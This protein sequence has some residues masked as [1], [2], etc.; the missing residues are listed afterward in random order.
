M[1][2]I[3]L[4]KRNTNLHTDAGLQLLDKS[5][6]KV[7]IIESY[8]ISNDGVVIS[9]NARHEKISAKISKEPIVIETDGTEAIIIKRTDIESNTKKFEDSFNAGFELAL[10]R[11]PEFK[12]IVNKE[13]VKQLSLLPQ[14]HKNTNAWDQLNFLCKQ[15]FDAKPK[16]IHHELD[17]QIL[18]D[19]MHLKK[20]EMLGFL[21]QKLQNWSIQLDFSVIENQEENVRDLNGKD[22][23]ELLAKKN[24]NL[25]SLQKMF[26]LDVEY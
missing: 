3:K 7:G 25:Y 17:N 22:R 10:E 21:R 12:S 9:G 23:F 8:T 1:I 2:K 11:G 6:D 4:D 15:Q 26:N 20:A 5:I 18:V 14:N 16:L 24:S 13:E 19:L